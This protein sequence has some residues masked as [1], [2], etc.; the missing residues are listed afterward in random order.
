MENLD[1]K[2]LKVDADELISIY[3]YIIYNLDLPSLY[4][5]LDFIEHFTGSITKQSMI[6]YYFTSVVGSLEFIMSS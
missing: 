3:L 5:Q 2:F 6:G 4:T 1:T